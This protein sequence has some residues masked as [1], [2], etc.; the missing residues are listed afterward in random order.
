[1]NANN[2]ELSFNAP[3]AS[4]RPGAIRLAHLDAFG[5]R[6]VLKT[7]EWLSFAVATQ[8]G[9]PIVGAVKDESSTVGYFADLVVRR[10]GMRIPGSPFVGWKTAYMG[11]NLQPDVD[12]LAALEALA[13]FAFREL[14]CAC[15]EERDRGVADTDADDVGWERKI[16]LGGGADYK[17][18]CGRIVGVPHFRG[19]RSREVGELRKIA[20][21]VYRAWWRTRG[22][23][24][25]LTG[26]AR[27]A[28]R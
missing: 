12:R 20:R 7:R 18:W 21:R 8:P 1:L 14:G 19:A 16:D 27:G 10:Y 3:A 24:R 23:L 22:R 13:P 4:R 26:R 17:R 5:D 9:E 15:V 28:R 2:G 25:A 11:F 6:V